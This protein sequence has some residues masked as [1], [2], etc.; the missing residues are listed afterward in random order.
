MSNTYKGGGRGSCDGWRFLLFDSE[1]LRLVFKAFG[2]RR[3]N[4]RAFG[5]WR[6][7]RKYISMSYNIYKGVL[8]FFSIWIMTVTEVYLT[9][10]YGFLPLDVTSVSRTL[11]DWL[12]LDYYVNNW[13][14]LGIF[15][16]WIAT[17]IFCTFSR[18]SFIGLLR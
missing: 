17:L 18:F 10:F 6:L 14:T 7:L 5:G 4:F 13:S 9:H 1:S 16:H 2:G 15:F 11:L 8:S 3:S 12:W